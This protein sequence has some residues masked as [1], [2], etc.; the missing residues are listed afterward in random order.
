MGWELGYDSSWDRFIGYGVP[1][2][3]DHPDC[4]NEID[5]G[6]AHVCSDSQPYGGEGCGLYF[7]L[8]HSD[9]SGRCDRCSND[10]DPF[11]PKKEHPK[12]IKWMLTHRSWEE[13]R[14]EN[15]DKVKLLES[16]G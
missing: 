2:Y 11:E 16:E 4:N 15:P 8:D 1:A 12:W 13:W 7:C 6:L 14:K 10:E 5:R 9:F 3:C